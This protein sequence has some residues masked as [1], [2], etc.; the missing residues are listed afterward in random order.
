[1]DEV[2]KSDRERDVGR[3]VEPLGQRWLAARAEPEREVPRTLQGPR[4]DVV[5][6]GRLVGLGE[7]VRRGVTARVNNRARQPAGPVFGDT[8]GEALREC[9]D[10]DLLSKALRRGAAD[11]GSALDVREDE[12]QVGCCR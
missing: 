12:F 8:G 10:L 6:Q 4:Q 3:W 7:D 9:E 11:L 2:R 5:R 1:M